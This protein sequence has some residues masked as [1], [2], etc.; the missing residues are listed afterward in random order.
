MRVLVV[1]PRVP[2][3]LDAKVPW[4]FFQELKALAEQGVE[5]C[6]ASTSAPDYTLPGVEFRRIGALSLRRRPLSTP[7][8]ARYLARWR[9][10]L[11]ESGWRAMARQVQL[12]KWNLALLEVARQWRP[13]LIHSHWAFPANS[14]GALAARELDLPLVMTLRGIEHQIVPEFGYGHCLDRFFEE[15]LVKALHCASRITVCCQDSV[16]R[17]HSLGIV[18]DRKIAHIYHAVD[19]SRLD[20]ETANDVSVQKALEMEG[21]RIITCIARMEDH[22]RKGHATLLQAFGLLRQ[23]Y[24]DVELL[25]IGDGADRPSLESLAE[26]FGVSKHVRFFGRAHPSSIGSL[27]RLSVCSVLPSFSE[28]FANVVFESLV[29]GTPVVSSA[30]A[31]PK[32]VLPLGPFGFLFQPGD[33]EGL[34][35]AVSEI[36]DDPAEANDMARRGGEFVRSQMSLENRAAAFVRIY[37]QVAGKPARQP[38]LALS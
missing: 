17:V 9:G 3:S 27:L 38:E 30:I 1:V 7:R 33:V 2:E 26:E 20:G 22:G 15:A 8:V 19:A 31:A 28:A 4:H 6:V 34:A 11:P 35:S 16:E 10:G 5:L 14:G 21:Q 29:T 37:E 18:D 12:V 23:K 25:L 32:D 13:D 24:S 36:L